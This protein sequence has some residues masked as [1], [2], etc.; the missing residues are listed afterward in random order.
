MQEW[1]GILVDVSQKDKLIF[2]K[3]KILG[4][5]KS[6]NDDWTLYRIGVPPKNIDEMIGQIQDNMLDGFYFH[7]YEDDELIVVFKKRIFRIKTDKSTWTGAIEYGMSLGIPE[8][9]LDFYPC[10]EKD[11][12]Y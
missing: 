11:E 5:K 7:F 6:S 3:L 10:R 1:H 9:Q 2:K 8:R 12:T 4:Q